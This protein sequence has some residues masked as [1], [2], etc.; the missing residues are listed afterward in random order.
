MSQRA[1][2]AAPDGVAVTLLPR[3]LQSSDSVDGHDADCAVTSTGWLV[4]RMA[5]LTRY[6]L[7]VPFP[8]TIRISAVSLTL[9]GIDRL[10]IAA[11]TGEHQGPTSYFGQAAIR[12][13]QTAGGE[14][15]VDALQLVPAVA[16][17]DERRL[18][19]RVGRRED[20][21]SMLVS[22][23]VFSQGFL[24]LLLATRLSPS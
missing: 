7:L 15:W 10:A 21:L 5:G 17:G 6:E 22:Q 24:C 20:R 14:S 9:R 4:E 12:T 3:L 1:V 16:V 13:R 18:V 8:S 19:L 2:P 23:Q 11:C